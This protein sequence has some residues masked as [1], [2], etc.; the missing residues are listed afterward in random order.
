MRDF[1]AGDEAPYRRMMQ[2][3]WQADSE[4]VLEALRQSPLRE[5]R[6]AQFHALF[7]YIL[8]NRDGIDNWRL[9]PVA[10]RRS[11]GRRIAPVRCGSGVIEKNIEV[12]INRRFKRQGRSWTRAGA[13]HLAQLLWL[14][15]HPADWN[16]WWQKTALA[17]T[18][19]NPGWP[20]SP[21]PPN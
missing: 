6:P 15:S 4:A 7:G 21:R 10:L 16:H 5:N 19:V 1:G 18:K 2:P 9:L 13:E 17:K 11:I 20:S 8:G 14:Q 12:Q 3:V